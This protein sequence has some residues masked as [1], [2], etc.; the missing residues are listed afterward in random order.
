MHWQ[1]IE[2]APK[3][4]RVVLLYSPETDGME[5]DHYGAGQ[6]ESTGSNGDG[7]WLHFL[8][9]EPT[10]WAPI[11]PPGSDDEYIAIRRESME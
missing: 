2:T 9:G 1:P 7:Y 6:W 10:H 5:L 3:D 8:D 4:G 11:F